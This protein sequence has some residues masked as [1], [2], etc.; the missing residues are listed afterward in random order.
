MCIKN[1]FRKKRAEQQ[2]LSLPVSLSMNH[3]LEGEALT[4]ESLRRRLSRTSILC[5]GMPPFLHACCTLHAIFP[6]WLDVSEHGAANDEL[7]LCKLEVRQARVEVLYSLLIKSDW[8]WELHVL[9]LCVPKSNPLS[10]F[11]QLYLVCVRW[12]MW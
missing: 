10:F 2:L 9:D 6:G 7:V 4:V 12:W 11:I 1:E 3:Y 8:S 5:E